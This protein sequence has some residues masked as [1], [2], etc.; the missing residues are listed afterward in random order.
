LQ[1]AQLTNHLVN[2]A[3]PVDL[4]EL[5]ILSCKPACDW[6]SVNTGR[7]WPWPCPGAAQAARC[8]RYG[9]QLSARLRHFECESMNEVYDKT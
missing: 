4:Y 7:R 6:L 2:G 3:S 8:T 5:S 9:Q 1:E